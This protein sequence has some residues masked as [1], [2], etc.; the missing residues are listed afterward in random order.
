[1]WSWFR[2]LHDKLDAI[3]AGQRATQVQLD[4]ME[5]ALY[6]LML[7][8]PAGPVRI[9][10]TGD[11]QM[12]DTLQFEVILPPVAAPD[13][14][15][16]EVAVD[17]DGTLATFTVA[18]DVTKLENLEGAQGATVTVTL[19][20][21]DDAGNKSEPSVKIAV[22]ADTFAPPKPG[23]IDLVVINETFKPAAEEASS[24]ETPGAEG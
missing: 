15:S 17:I 18:G 14:V 20:D 24:P 8:A 13:V 19:V 23:E 9:Q 11:A 4:K 5:R 21:V 3:I 2:R 12:A 7:R 6:D 16:R 10:V 1:M 22:L